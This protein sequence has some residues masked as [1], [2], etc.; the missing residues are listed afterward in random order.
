[1]KLSKSFSE[2][3]DFEVFYS[4]KTNSCNFVLDTINELCSFE[5]VSK[6]EWNIVKKYKPREIVLNGPS[7]NKELLLD[8]LD[9]GTE[10]IYFNVDNDTD[11][12]IIKKL[13][14]KYLKHIKIGI[15]VFINKS[16]I[17][18]RFG[19]DIE[20]Q[21][22]ENVIKK[23]NS[24]IHGFH[25]HMS[26]NNFEINN[27]I[28]IIKK[29]KQCIIDYN[30]KIDFIDI[31]GGLP[32]S[33]DLIYYKAMYFELPEIMKNN[34]KKTKI[35]SEVGRNLVENS[36]LLKAQVVSTKLIGSDTF[37]I[38]ID[39]NIMH[40]PC[41]WEKKFSVEYLKTKKFSEKVFYKI[42]IFG[43]SCMQID[44]IVNNLIVNSEPSVDDYVIINNIGA[45]SIS[46]ASNFITDIPK[47]RMMV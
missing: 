34:F 37:N 28:N 36:F 23:L 12:S 47:V 15:R 42:N 9:S 14:K 5:I 26:T 11:V 31:G 13:E 46:Q 24:N 39:T 16:E 43:N 35:I 41:F 7:K 10:T 33:N 44:N 38:S 25:F 29:I 30:F 20:S 45:Y 17:W 4:V 18:N 2:L 22:F 8:I 6:D 19:Y 27:Y 40:F 32:G 3:N 21:E 1:M